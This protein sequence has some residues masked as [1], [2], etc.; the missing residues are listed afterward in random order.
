MPTPKT[1]EVAL[2]PV[3]F[4]SCIWC[5]PIPC[6]LNMQ[7]IALSVQH[8]QSKGV[9]ELMWT[10]W[11][12]ALIIRTALLD[13]SITLDVTWQISDVTIWLLYGNF[14]FDDVLIIL[15]GVQSLPVFTRYSTNIKKR[16]LVGCVCV[17]FKFPWVCFRE[18]LAKLDDIW[19]SYH[20]YDKCDIFLRHSV[21]FYE[22]G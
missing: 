16:I 19:L 9:W 3:E 6:L 13:R 8:N 11:T 12:F 7:L 1:P 2:C 21:Y 10:I 20:K 14:I 18:E 15:Y 5:K 22:S 17:C 4:Y